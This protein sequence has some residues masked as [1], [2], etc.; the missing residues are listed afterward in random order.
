V[1]NLPEPAVLAD[2]FGRMEELL[3]NYAAGDAPVS[4]PNPLRAVEA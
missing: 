2:V 4:R 3:D 1:T